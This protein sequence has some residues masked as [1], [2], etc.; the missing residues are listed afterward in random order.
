MLRFL[1]AIGLEQTVEYFHHRHQLWEARRELSVEAEGNR[2]Q[3]TKNLQAVRT[4]TAELDAN[5]AL[6]RESLQPVSSLRRS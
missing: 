6:L 5:M 3:L 1:I 2:G 4:M